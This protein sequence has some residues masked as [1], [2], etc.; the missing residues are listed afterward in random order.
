[1]SL[2]RERPIVGELTV[3]GIG[4]PRRHLPAFD[5]AL[6]GTRPRPRVAEG[7]ER[8]RRHLSGSMAGLAILLEDGEDV[9][10]ERHGAS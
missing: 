10:A 5:L 7:Q 6:D 4:E 1:M 8:H 3:R 9:F 2:L